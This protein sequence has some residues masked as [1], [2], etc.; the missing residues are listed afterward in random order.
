MNPNLILA[1]VLALGTF[2]IL[3]HFLP[4]KEV[5][6]AAETA[7]QPQEITTPAQAQEAE[8]PAEEPRVST[9]PKVE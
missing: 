6:P 8:A 9:P 3:Q 2:Q 7:S 4:K 5:A 1:L